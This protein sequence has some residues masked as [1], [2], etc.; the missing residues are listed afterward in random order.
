MG[1]NFALTAP[2]CREAAALYEGG[3][4]TT[5]I[6]D[7][8]QVSVTAVRSALQLLGVPLRTRSEAL[9]IQWTI[10]ELRIRCLIDANECWLW[11]G[12]KK[13]NGYGYLTIQRRTVYAH[14]LA[15]ELQ[16]G[17]VPKGREVCHECDVRHCV[18]PDHLFA[19]TRKDNMR[20]AKSKGRL[21]CGV[22]HG[23]RVKAGI[24]R[25]AQP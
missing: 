4:A 11:Q 2:Q 25:R 16:N 19:G 17:A 3:V 15:F 10:D 12:S 8:M 13:R 14:R 21:S 6:A 5:A 9:S 7:A 24:A 22:L 1:R 23:I 18:N 20:D